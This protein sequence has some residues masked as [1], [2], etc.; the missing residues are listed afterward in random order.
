ML[1][2]TSKNMPADPSRD[3]QISPGNPPEKSAFADKELAVLK[4]E[5]LQGRHALELRI[6][7]LETQLRFLATREDLEKAKNRAVW[8]T[9]AMVISL[10][11]GVASVI[12][13]VARL[14]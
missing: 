2:Y 5:S 6:V 9:A 12:G 11:A 8:A 13:A 1:A 4:N 14:P 3:I 7:A 10:L